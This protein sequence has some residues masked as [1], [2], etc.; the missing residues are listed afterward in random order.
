[1]KRQ[2]MG[3]L[4]GGMGGMGMNRMGMGLG[5]GIGGMEMGGGLT[6]GKFLKRFLNFCR[7]EECNL[8]FCGSG[9]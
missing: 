5:G 1:V 4:G 9:E 2:Y 3:G 7:F 6:P 8:D